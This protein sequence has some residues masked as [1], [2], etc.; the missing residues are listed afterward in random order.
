MKYFCL[1]IL[2]LFCNCTP[3]KNLYKIHSN[4]T[5]DQNLVEVAK[6]YLTKFQGVNED[7]LNKMRVKINDC[8]DI[9][10]V[11]FHIV[12]PTE[13]Y[14]IRGRLWYYRVIIRKRDCEILSFRREVLG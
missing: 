10:S 6:V 2:F 4:C 14:S 5:T 11:Q 9:V 3:N 13:G 7:E 8:D 12:F 1:L